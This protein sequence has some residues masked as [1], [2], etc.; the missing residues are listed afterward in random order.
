MEDLPLSILIRLWYN[1]IDH[2]PAPLSFG[3]IIKLG[4][5]VNRV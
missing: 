2:A 4:G 5:R 1:L 3:R